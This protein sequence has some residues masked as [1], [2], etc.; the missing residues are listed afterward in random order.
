[1][2]IKVTRQGAASPNG[3]TMEIHCLE[4]KRA[5]LDQLL[6]RQREILESRSFGVASDAQILEYEIR[7]E[8]IHE[9]C[10]ELANS[11]AA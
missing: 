8:I 10:N 6:R 11:T 9:I 2:K 5:E 1:M 4:E 3:G 7:R